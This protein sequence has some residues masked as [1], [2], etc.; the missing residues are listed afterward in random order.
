MYAGAEH[1]KAEDAHQVGNITQYHAVESDYKKNTREM[2]CISPILVRDPLKRQQLNTSSFPCGRCGPC[3][4]SRSAAWAV[5]LKVELQY[6]YKPQFLTLT[7]EDEYLEYTPDGELT[8][9]KSTLQK[10]I[11]RLRKYNDAYWIQDNPQ[12]ADFSK[13]IN[14]RQFR[15]Y[16]IGEYGDK[17]QRP[18]YHMLAFNLHDK[19]NER[20]E[21]I[22]K[23]GFIKR[24]DISEAS[25]RYVTN[26]VNKLTFE[27]NPSAQPEFALMSR[28]PPIGYQYI[29]THSQYHQKTGMTYMQDGPQKVTLPRLYRDKMLSG[30]QKLRANW[31]FRKKLIQEDNEIFKE[32]GPKMFAVQKSRTDDKIR[33][34]TNAKN[35][36]K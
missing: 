19:T 30:G 6:A 22:W 21:E 12:R 7:Q 15:Y 25:I 31:E 8:L 10:F 5:R 9:N 34:F 11:K 32:Y 33:K 13:D 27:K 3:R 4:K 14:I 35:K 36:R 20:L 28:R 2:P 24:G 16:A 1:S 18:H 26:Y 29:N 23:R 17:F